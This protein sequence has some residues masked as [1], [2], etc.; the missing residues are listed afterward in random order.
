MSATDAQLSAL[1]W[2]INRNGDGLFDRNQVLVAAGE[3]AP[4]M[5]ST[6]NA[7]V[8]LGYAEFYMDR[9]RVRV[10]AEGRSLKLGMVRESEG[11]PEEWEDA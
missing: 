9:R 2:L 4:V 10:T 11:E 3:R 7:L 1:K 8:K 6:W 5:R